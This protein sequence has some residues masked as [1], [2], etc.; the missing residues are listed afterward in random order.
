MDDNE[1]VFNQGAASDLETLRATIKAKKAAADEIER[2]R[3][4]AEEKKEC[5]ITTLSWGE[6]T[7]VIAAREGTD[8]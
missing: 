1:A 7:Q 8:I 2:K 6:K 5:L 3:I 4:L